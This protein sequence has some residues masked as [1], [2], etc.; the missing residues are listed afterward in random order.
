M[1]KIYEIL[2]KYYGYDSFRSGQEGIIK[3]IISGRDVSAVMPTGAGK[4]ICYQIPALYFDGITIVISPLISLMQDQVRTLISM[5]VRA[6]YLNPRW[7]CA[8]RFTTLP[9]MI[10]GLLSTASFL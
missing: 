1:E 6:A 2:K 3:N 7:I 10:F 8:L 9:M 5:G 4:S